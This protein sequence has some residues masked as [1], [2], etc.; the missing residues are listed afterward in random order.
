MSRRRFTLTSF[1]A[2]ALMLLVGATVSI[3]QPFF[4]TAGDDV[5]S[6]TDRHDYIAGRDGNDTLNGVARWDVLRGAKGDDTIN[7]GRGRD[8]AFGGPGSDTVNGETGNDR[9][10]VRDGE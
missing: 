10:R 7:A 6:G 1:G 3:A 9:I 2:G 8:F 5:I 4:G